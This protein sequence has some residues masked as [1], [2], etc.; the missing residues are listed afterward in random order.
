MLIYG[1]NEKGDKI[2]TFTIGA[3][4]EIQL[5]RW[6]FWRIFIKDVDSST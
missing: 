1:R 4:R 3:D 2:A 6:I 5:F